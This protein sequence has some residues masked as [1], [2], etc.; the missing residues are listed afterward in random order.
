MRGWVDD[1]SNCHSGPCTTCWVKTGFQP[2]WFEWEHMII[3]SLFKLLSLSQNWSR[4]LFSADIM[5]F[6]MAFFRQGSLLSQKV[7]AEYVSLFSAAADEGVSLVLQW[8]GLGLPLWPVGRKVGWAESQGSST[9]SVVIEVLIQHGRDIS[10]SAL[11]A[12]NNLKFGTFGA[13]WQ[14]FFFWNYLLLGWFD[15]AGKRGGFNR[16]WV[17]GQTCVS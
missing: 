13:S 10:L 7:C 6:S 1:S 16:I 9:S 3:E 17:S 2:T 11:P 14:H 4:N 12:P 15:V 8:F 5:A